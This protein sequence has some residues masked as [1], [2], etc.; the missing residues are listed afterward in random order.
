MPFAD[1][2]GGLVALFHRFNIYAFGWNLQF[3]EVIQSG[4]L[5]GLD[6]VFSDW[7]D[8]LADEMQRIT[9]L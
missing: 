2:N 6:G 1:W 4:L 3:P 9:V 7:S 5:M 8:R